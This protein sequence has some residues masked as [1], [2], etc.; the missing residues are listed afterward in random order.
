MTTQTISKT[1]ANCAHWAEKGNSEG[2]CRV[3]APQFVAF[4]VD[5]ET[6]FETRFPVTSAED[7]CGEFEAR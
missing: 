6:R 2:E 5:S 1:C 4:Q 3:K 7:W